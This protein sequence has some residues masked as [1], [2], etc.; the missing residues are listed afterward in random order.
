MRPAGVL[1][2][3]R[4]GRSGPLFWVRDARGEPFEEVEDQVR[5]D[6]RK[7]GGDQE[8]VRADQRQQPDE[9]SASD[10][11]DQ[12]DTVFPLQAGQYQRLTCD[13]PLTR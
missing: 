1:M 3:L 13:R 5:Q 10:R 11:C 7:V 2:S 4:D 6:R 8:L 9:R 12:Q